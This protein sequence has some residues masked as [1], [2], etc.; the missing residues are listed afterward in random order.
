MPPV[1]TV[2]ACNL[3]DMAQTR[4]EFTVL[5]QPPAE[6]VDAAANR[7][8]I[9]AAARE[10]VAAGGVASLSM[11]EVAQAAG[12]GVGTVYRRFKDRAGL[13]HALLDERER[14]LQAAFISGPPPLGPGASAAD[15]ITAFL[16]E[17][18]DRT[19]AQLDLLLFAETSAPAARFETSYEVYRQHLSLLLDE[20]APRAD[21]G[22][23]AD[24]LL[25]CAGADLFA[26]QRRQR[27][28]D[29]DTMKAGMR[30]LVDGLCR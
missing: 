30:A 26:W 29:V 2:N 14:E 23:L 27:G 10:L 20:L 21:P 19:D 15:R 6:R 11:D 18:I 24:V 25:A 13:A 9:L 12:V 28:I 8:R 17:L 3:C 22:Y 1:R 7:R 5:G 4:R 16:D